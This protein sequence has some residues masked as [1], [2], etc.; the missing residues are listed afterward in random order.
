MSNKVLAIISYITL[1]GWLIAFFS[2]DKSKNNSLVNY[3]LNQSLG[4]TIVSII[5]NVAITII[6][7]MVPSLAFLSF[8]GYAIFILMIL[9]IIN[10]N[11]E[12]EAS[13]PII[14]KMFENKF[15]FIN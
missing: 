5:F 9:G 2:R 11:N 12:K 7:G 15:S 8:V 3:H 14:G 4:L 6:V 1:I 13:L 10:A